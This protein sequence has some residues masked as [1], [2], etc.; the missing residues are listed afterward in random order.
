MN[1]GLV[2]NLYMFKMMMNTC[3]SLMVLNYS[4]DDGVKNGDI[5]YE[6]MR[7]VSHMFMHS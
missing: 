3:I 2:M 5:L 4:V 6:L 7:L 1:D